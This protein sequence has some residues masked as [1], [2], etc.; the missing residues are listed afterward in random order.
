MLVERS[1]LL[2]LLG[3]RPDT[4]AGSTQRYALRDTARRAIF[5]W[6]AG[7]NLTVEVSEELKGEDDQP[8]V[9]LSGTYLED[10]DAFLMEARDHSGEASEPDDPR[11]AAALWRRLVRFMETVE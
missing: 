5:S 9:T 10:E 11:A 8:L 6:G 7:G 2:D 1:E 3:L 4:P